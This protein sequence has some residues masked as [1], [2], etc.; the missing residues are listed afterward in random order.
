MYAD[1]MI[2]QLNIASFA[3]DVHSLFQ[4]FYPH[5]RIVV[6]TED[7][8]DAVFPCEGWRI[9]VTED[10]LSVS[11]GGKERSV[12][13]EGLPRAEV[14]NHLKRLIYDA[15]CAHTGR[16]LPWGTLTGIRPTKLALQRL[17]S[18]ASRDTIAAFMR[19]VYRTGED[20]IELCTR[21]AMREAKVLEKIAG[22]KWKKDTKEA[23]ATGTPEGDGNESATGMPMGNRNFPAAGNLLVDGYSLYIGIPFC[24]SI[25]LYCSFSSY[26]VGAYR[27][28]VEEY[29]TAL[30]TEID[31]VA[32]MFSDR[33]LTTVYIGGGTP[34]ALSDGQLSRLLDKVESAF[35]MTHV[36]EFTVEAG[37]PDSLDR[38]KLAVIASHFGGNIRISINPQTLQQKT[39][40][41]IGRRHT[42]EDIRRCYADARAAGF[43]HINMDLIV[44]LPGETVEDVA[45]T[46][47]QARQLAPDNLT[48]HALAIKRSSRLHEILTERAVRAAAE[49]S[50]GETEAARAAAEASRGETEAARAAA[51]AFRTETEA[52]R[53]AESLT[54]EGYRSY[55]SAHGDEIMAMAHSLAADMGMYP[56]YLYRQKNIAGN[57]ENVGFAP[58]GKEGLYNIII[59]EEVQDIIALGAGA[60]CKCLARDEDGRPLPKAK[61]RRC[62]NVKNVEEYILRVDE[63]IERKRK[64]YFGST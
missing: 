16:Q 40:E 28:L 53:A 3:Y 54:E 36:L 1:E 37:R 50:K 61:I 20:K 51:E 46:L 52:S 27:P 7:K 64:L 44:G 49:A 14:K 17:L 29:L 32:G 23:Y 59:M 9:V 41:L 35:D 11:T 12:S 13:V 45:D 34:T 15:L 48:V 43:T 30:F 22:V 24:P 4:A 55:F 38:D 62:E 25:C 18:G 47:A 19:D 42:T 10:M 33:P 58:E 39:L 6:V 26:A 5:T 56:Y 60:A 21:I 63:M 8:G 2:I 31:A 57:L